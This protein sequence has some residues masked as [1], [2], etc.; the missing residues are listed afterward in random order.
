MTDFERALKATLVY[1]GGLS[2]NSADPGGLTNFG[3]TQASFWHY[4]SD[5]GL[6]LRSVK[7]ITGTEVRD[8][9]QTR[10][11]DPVT[12]GRTWPL[13]AVLFDVAV[14]SGVGTALWMLEQ[15]KQ[16][17]P[18]TAPNRMKALALAVCDVRQQ[19]F[20]DIVKRRPL[21]A[22]FLTGWLRRVN[23]QRALCQT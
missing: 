3:I 17:V 11:W 7:T 10:Y 16:T 8:I 14:N 18:P 22:V 6:P 13:N 12:Q 5:K 2:N 23:E 9:Y 4:L 15:A 1:E 19:F 20:K 21:S